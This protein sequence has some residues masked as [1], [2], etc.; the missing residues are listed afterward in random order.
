MLPPFLGWFVFA[1]LVGITMLGAGVLGCARPRR[2]LAPVPQ[3]LDQE[4][5]LSE[6]VGMPQSGIAPAGAATLVSRPAE[7]RSS[8]LSTE[9]Q[10]HAH[11]S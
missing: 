11:A 9:R 8:S 10:D 5:T 1:P 7:L 3:S 2:H 4:L 6:P